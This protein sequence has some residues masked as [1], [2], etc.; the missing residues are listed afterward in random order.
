MKL[1]K[2][3]RCKRT[4]QAIV[5]GSLALAGYGMF[6]DGHVELSDLKTLGVMAFFASVVT[7]GV[8]EAVIPLRDLVAEFYD[9]GRRDERKAAR[10][11]TVTQLRVVPG[12]KAVGS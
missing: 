11:S 10:Q 4:L 5:A 12:E 7:L 9:K 2:M 1:H 6:G 8:R 3:L